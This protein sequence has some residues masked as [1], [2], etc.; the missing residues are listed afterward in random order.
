MIECG[1]CISTIEERVRNNYY[2]SLASFQFDLDLMVKNT[3]LFNGED[4]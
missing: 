4:N 1:I 3:I 2:R